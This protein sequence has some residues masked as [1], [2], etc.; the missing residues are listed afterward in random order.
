M[1]NGAA[2]PRYG[3]LTGLP[4]IPRTPLRV[5]D[6][7]NSSSSVATNGFNIQRQEPYNSH[8]TTVWQPAP[9]VHA[10]ELSS[11][12]HRN[13][14]THVSMDS[15]VSPSSVAQISLPAVEPIFHLVERNV[16]PR[17]P[18]IPDLRIFRVLLSRAVRNF[19][20]KPSVNDI[21]IRP[22]RSSLDF[23]ICRQ[24]RPAAQSM[25][26]LRGNASMHKWCW[27]FTVRHAALRI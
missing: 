13:I 14:K 25:S 24:Q 20:F 5:L 3:P 8:R 7:R 23:H 16:I 1:T 27:Y 26:S 17:S 11:Y 15:P 4:W 2:G 12:T 22:E 6:T 18:S 19:V 21:P 9:P 10:S